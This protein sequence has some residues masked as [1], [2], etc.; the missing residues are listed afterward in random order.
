MRPVPWEP[1]QPATVSSS[2]HRFA[3]RSDLRLQNKNWY[4]RSCQPVN[5]KPNL[6]FACERRVS[7]LS[8][9]DCRCAVGS[10]STWLPPE[11]V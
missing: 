5:L 9:V 3:D 7:M 2:R 11:F 8:P 10:R 6:F 1:A 4:D